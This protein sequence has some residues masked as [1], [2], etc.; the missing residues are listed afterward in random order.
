[1]TEVLSPEVLPSSVAEWVERLTAVQARTVA[2]T[3][4]LGRE[5]ASAK[6][7]V[8]HGQWLE[9]LAAMHV[10]ERKVQRLMVV[11]EHPV[12]ANP[13]HWTAFPN[14][15]RTLD[16]LARLDEAEMLAAI[17][18]GE[19]HPSMQRRE[20]EALVA[21]LYPA[22]A[23]DPEPELEDGAADPAPAEPTPAAGPDTVPTVPEPEAPES[24]AAGTPPMSRTLDP[25]R[26]RDMVDR[27]LNHLDGHVRRVAKRQTEVVARLGLASPEELSVMAA[28][29]SAALWLAKII[30]GGKATAGPASSAL[31]AFA[32][33]TVDAWGAREIFWRAT[34]GAQWVRMVAGSVGRYPI[35]IVDSARALELG[36][37]AG[38]MSWEFAAQALAI[39]IE[40]WEAESL[41]G[42]PSDRPVEPG[43]P[44]VQDP[45]NGGDAAGD[46]P[47]APAAP[48]PL[49]LEES[50]VGDGG[51]GLDSRL[52]SSEADVDGLGVCP[53]TSEVVPGSAGGV[54]EGPAA[55]DVPGT[56]DAEP[57]VAAGSAS[58]SPV[59]HETVLLD[60]GGD[61]CGD[62][63][64]DDLDTE[65]D[66]VGGDGPPLNQL[67][68]RRAQSRHLV[69][70]GQA[71]LAAF[72]QLAQATAHKGWR[73]ELDALCA[74]AATHGATTE[75]LD[76]VEAVAAVARDAV[77]I[78]QPPV[79]AGGRR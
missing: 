49:D 48:L 72:E 25:A 38:D 68:R 75:I 9:L 59:V 44:D 28:E 46:A 45:E 67:G 12:L 3:V 70:K 29:C 35:P 15:Y 69:A 30:D 65:P 63:E 14:A 78:A 41:A 19:V 54:T 79:P 27:A 17:E 50:P 52:S 56:G 40:E 34:E 22:P 74:H 20:A 13:V 16:V 8:K 39:E 58:P 7:V 62:D 71:V 64:P 21:R 53:S 57:S 24:D 61:P 47:D 2:A 18:A 11:A 37:R 73:D 60:F 5:W 26:D 10:D 55:D 6:I 33:G 43:A 76:T 51:G 42:S 23:P 77:L 31:S 36:A 66:P 1:M 32:G 4:E